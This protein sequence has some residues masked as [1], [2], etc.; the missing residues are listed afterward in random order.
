MQGHAQ[1]IVARRQQHIVAWLQFT[2][3]RPI[4]LRMRL[5][6]RR[7]Y[8]HTHRGNGK[9]RNGNRVKKFHGPTI[10][11]VHLNDSLARLGDTVRLAPAPSAWPWKCAGRIHSAHTL[12]TKRTLADD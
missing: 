6:R 10:T 12:S 3:H 1:T 5:Q 4:V 9:N 2:Q 7:L 8:S 11:P